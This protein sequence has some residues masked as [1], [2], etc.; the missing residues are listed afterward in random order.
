MKRLSKRTIWQRCLATVLA[1]LMVNSILPIPTIQA[2]AATT[3]HP[4][5]VTV[6]VTDE[7]GNA[8]EGASVAYTIEKK[9]SVTDG[10]DFSTITN[11]V[12]TDV[13]GVVDVLDSTAYLSDCLI[14]T[15]S[16]SKTGYA[17]NSTTLSATDI[18]SDNQNFSVQLTETAVTQ[19]IEGVS[20]TVLDKDYIEG[21]AQQ[22]ITKVET[23]TEDVEVQYSRDGNSWSGDVPEEMNVGEYPVYVKITK[24]GY[25]EYLSGKLTAKINAI[26]ITGIDIVAKNISYNGKEQQLVDLTGTFAVGDKVT[27]IVNNDAENKTVWAVTDENIGDNNIPVK[28]AV[29]TYS[30]KLEVDRGINYNVFS[31]TVDVTLKEGFELGDLKVTGLNDTYTG[32]ERPAVIIENQ[33]DYTLQYKC[34]KDSAVNVDSLS[35]GSIPMIKDAGSYI[36]WVKAVKENYSDQDVAVESAK[37]AVTPYNVYIAKKDPIFSFTNASYNDVVSSDTVSKSDLESGKKYD[38]KAVDGEEGKFVNAT[39]KYEIVL[40][41]DNKDIAVIDTT[42]GELTVNAPGVITVMATLSGDTNYNECTIIHTLYVCVE[43][44]DA[45]EL[46]GFEKATVDYVVGNKDGVP[47]NSV[48]L[49][50]DDDIAEITYSIEKAEDYGLEIDEAGLVSVKNYSKLI[51][52]VESS[53]NNTLIVNVKATKA[54][55]EEKV[56][57]EVFVIYP[58]DY[59]TY[60]LYITMREIPDDAYKIYESSNESTE[61]NLS[62]E[63]TAPNGNDDWYKTEV[64]IVPTTDYDI[65]RGDELLKLSENSA[66]S[67]SFVE[68]VKFGTITNGTASDQ[69][70]EDRIVYL[71]HRETKEITGKI[72]TTVKKLDNIKPNSLE[73]VFPDIEVDEAG[74]KNY[75]EE[76][77]VIFKAEDTTSGVEKFKW[78]YEKETGSSES[79]LD[80]DSG[81]VFASWD[82]QQEKYVASLTL[83]IESAQQ[84]RGK[85]K[86]SAVD[87]AGNES[88]CFTDDG[89]FVIDTIPAKQTVTYEIR[90]N[91]D[92]YEYPVVDEKH[93]FNNDVLFT[94]KIV[95]ANFIAEDVEITVVK[96]Q[97]EEKK[98]E[99]SWEKSTEQQDEYKATL[100][101]SEDGDYVVKM[102]Y[103]DRSNQEENSYTS[104][105][106]VV[107]KTTPVITYEYKDCS[108]ETEPQALI[109]TVKEHNFRASD[110]E[111]VVDE[112]KDI[113]GATVTTNDLQ[114]FLRQTKW[115]SEEDDKHSATISEEFVDA[116]YKLTFNYRDLALNSAEKVETKEFVVDHTAPDEMNIIYS[117]PITKKETWIDTILSTITLGFYNPT[118]TVTF[119]AYDRT[120]G[121]DKFIWSYKKQS[122]ASEKNIAEYSESEVKAQAT[123]DPTKYTATVTLPKEEAEQLRGNIS[124]TA[125]DNYQNKSST[126]TDEGYVIVVDTI[127]PELTVEYGEADGTQNGKDYYKKSINATFKVK[128]VNFFEEDISVYIQKNGGEQQKIESTAIEW[129]ESSE[130]EYIGT[131]MIEAKDDHSNDGEYVFIVNGIDKSKNE[132]VEYKSNIKV[133]DTISP[134]INVEYSDMTPQNTVVD[135]QGNIRKYFATANTATITINEHNF[136]S[137]GV[138]LNIE[139]KSAN[140][141]ALSVDEV[142]KKSGWETDGDKHTLT[143]TYT[144]DANYT[145]DITCTDLAKLDAVDYTPDYFTVDKT[146]PADLT[147]SYSISVLDTILSNISFGFYNAKAT[148]TITA[149]DNTSGI[150]SFKYS[151]L[152]AEGVSGVNTQIVNEVIPASNI[153]LSGGNATGTAKFEIPKDVLTENSQFN[154]TVRFAATDRA[155]NESEYFGDNKR[156]VVDNIAPTATVQYNEPVQQV[157]GISYYDGDISATVVINEANFYSEDVRIEVTRD[158]ATNV[159]NA[160]W[161]SSGTD[162]HTGTFTLSGDGDYVVKITY[163]D[164]SSNTMQEYSSEQMTIDTDIAEATITINGADGN[165]KAY[166]DEVVVKVSFE[167]QN[168]ESYEMNLYRISYAEKNVDVTDKFVTGHITTNATGGS[169]TLGTFAETAENDGIYTLTVLLKDKAGHSIEKSSTFTVNRYGSVYEYSD[170]LVSLIQDGG[171]YVQAIGEDLIITEYN[172]DRLVTD[173]LN[174]E[175]SRDGKPLD[176]VQ[177]N[178]TPEINDTVATGESGWFQYAYIISK[179]NFMSDGIYKVAISSKDATGNSPE[180][181]NYEDKDIL[182]RVDSTAPEITSITGLEEDVIN[183]TEREVKYIVYD[184]IGLKS[185]VVTLDGKEVDNITDFE[186]DLN[187]FSGTFTI[188]ES[189]SAQKVRVVVTDLAGNI[190]D[191]SAENFSS[192]YAFSDLVTVS[193]NI[194]VRW[195]ANKA[196]F[197]GSIAIVMV[198]ICGSIGAVVLFKRKKSEKEK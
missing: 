29:G 102:S 113:T 31:K 55:T 196:L 114:E 32:V 128:E 58:E 76:I 132:M 184:T 50:Y 172:A 122:D 5:C 59:A 93:Y 191:T 140:G 23:E 148:V 178:V 60:E 96:D 39:V 183:A 88:D 133:I 34:T 36:V 180:N 156:I 125:T 13:N 91:A 85:L 52:A 190:T 87:I 185:V 126:L 30:V 95:E 107:D 152:K 145:F 94:F 121:V 61:E 197:F 139:A 80:S 18:V 158:D 7:E 56:G 15:A 153:T 173:S 155:N 151:Y 137:D 141:T 70:E 168:F 90:E 131:Y 89:V 177:Y 2:Y 9:S 10:E 24:D 181:N 163:M 193:T 17:T 69:G 75:D 54:K 49:S 164:K 38:F 51:T 182:F 112:A 81:E 6:T 150:N 3:E 138:K 166:K 74:V 92:K 149:T 35:W 174:I 99:L 22:L 143:I 134:Q 167:D 27:W 186:A 98:Q 72:V 25:N 116:I 175:I 4:D 109:V 77:T 79:I 33:G 135:S 189:S 41:E 42:S 162:I 105:I 154:G 44:A 179:D 130:D 170:Y 198:V 46:I 115:V 97:G 65:I 160:D 110:I 78:A 11:T 14:I 123:E 187:N 64:K 144:G 195:Y 84:L 188:Q 192:A 45:G 147:V 86:I 129:T 194:L 63:L 40:S 43:S 103:K 47:E 161:N 16:V 120:S 159:I 53:E 19:D 83:P 26:D 111:L 1:L 117:N 146:R 142:C 165:G 106:I 100:T 48:E 119:T 67:V 20:V 62:K 82:S 124:F 127:A 171:A 136:D 73:I 176:E 104:E 68:S 8:V 12:T 71:Q 118:V 57:N 108:D 157:D 21:K 37:D 28:M 169:G 101:L 66:G